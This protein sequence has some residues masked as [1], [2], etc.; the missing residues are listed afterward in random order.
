MPSKRSTLA[1]IVL[2]AAPV[3]AGQAVD[4]ATRTSETPV[5]SRP[6]IE[7]LPPLDI[8][9]TLD[10][11]ERAGNQSSARLIVTITA[12]DEVSDL[13]L[14]LVLPTG[15]FIADGS[16]L[17]HGPLSLPH[18][19]A[20][21]FALPLRGP[22]GRDLPIRVEASCRVGTGP[23]LRIGQG[24]TLFSAPAVRGRSHLGAWEVMAVPL[25]D[26]HK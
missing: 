13:D 16:D 18:G 6:T 1:A 9:M 15:A 21:T 7:P 22:A 26:L 12:A 8:T 10:S 3:W 11:P 24:V 20:M 17:P 14:A 2:L 5:S 25:E 19:G 23:L 4:A